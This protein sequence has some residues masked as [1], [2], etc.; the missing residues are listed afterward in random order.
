M[1]IGPSGSLTL[2]RTPSAN[3]FKTLPHTWSA[4][5]CG[6]DVSYGATLAP[7]VLS[8]LGAIQVG[9]M[10]RSLVGQQLLVSASCV[11]I[12]PADGS[13]H[14]FPLSNFNW[15][16][17][18]QQPIAYVETGFGFDP[19]GRRTNHNLNVGA[20][21]ENNVSFFSFESCDPS[22]IVANF[23]IQLTNSTESGGA[24][25][26]IEILKPESNMEGYTGAFAGYHDY[27]IYSDFETNF[28]YPLSPTTAVGVYFETYQIDASSY[29][30]PNGSHFLVQIFSEGSKF[31]YSILYEG[32]VYHFPNA[33][34]PD[35]NP[36]I[37]LDNFYPYPAVYPWLTEQFAG[38]FYKYTTDSPSVRRPTPTLVRIGAELGFKM[39]DVFRPVSC[40]GMNVADVPIRLTVWNWVAAAQRTNDDLESPMIFQ[41]NDT[42]VIGSFDANPF[43]LVWT[44]RFSNN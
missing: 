39:Y 8:E 19:F 23:S 36:P 1:T 26:M 20:F 4:K 5:A 11:G 12:N 28:Q 29:P 27:G 25:S 32:V 42:N 24:S 14:S 3:A 21:S 43:E 9:G 13:S 6:A 40:D 16:L 30:S 33:N 31:T 18:I 15:T 41:G 44:N 17:P 22:P 7:A 10:W 38:D 34:Y 37:G 2:T 35:P